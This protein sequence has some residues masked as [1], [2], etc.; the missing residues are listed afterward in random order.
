MNVYDFDKTIYNGDST[1][2][3]YIFCL[4]RH[5]K[6]IKLLPNLFCEYIKFYLLKQ[7]TKT[8]FKEK[9][10]AFLKYAVYP[11]DLQ[12]FWATHKHKI[13]PWYL[14]QKKENDVIISASPTFLLE[15]ICKELKVFLIASKVDKFSGTTDGENCHSDEKVKRY[16][17]IFKS[18]K[19]DE[20]Y[21]DS[22]SDTP[23]AK[24]SHNAFIVKGNKLSPWRFK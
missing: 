1:A 14:K 17:E 8:Q 23:L 15:P 13:K 24:I 10:Y 7:G 22:Y 20:F 3:F 18:E 16:K 19:I 9:M 12:D 5:K 6:I 2:D 4:K 11:K 21:S